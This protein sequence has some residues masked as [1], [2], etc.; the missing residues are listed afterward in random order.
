MF[1]IPG[2]IYELAHFGHSSGITYN[3]QVLNIPPFVF[4]SITIVLLIGLVIIDLTTRPYVKKMKE[5]K[6]KLEEESANGHQRWVQAREAW[7]RL[8][9]CNLHDIVFLPGEKKGYVS[10]SQMTLLLYS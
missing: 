7:N 5:K 4:V 2:S 1:S 8:Y 10:A 9:Y 3:G 6:K